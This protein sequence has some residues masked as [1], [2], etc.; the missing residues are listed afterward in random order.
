MIYSD[1]ETLFLRI[2]VH[3]VDDKFTSTIIA[4]TNFEKHVS[5]KMELL[6]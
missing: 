3:E 2:L 6:Q 4:N 5:G 1:T